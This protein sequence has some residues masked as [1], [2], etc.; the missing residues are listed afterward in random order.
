M[1]LFKYDPRIINIDFIFSIVVCTNLF[2]LEGEHKTQ[3]FGIY[4]TVYLCQII[5]V[6]LPMF[7]DVDDNQIYIRIMLNIMEIIFFNNTNH[8]FH[9]IIRVFAV[10]SLVNLLSHIKF[11]QRPNHLRYTLY[12]PTFMHIE[13]LD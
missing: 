8:I 11:I 10:F 4:L 6:L 5:M 7:I 12:K 9:I 1:N 3:L 2:I 13:R